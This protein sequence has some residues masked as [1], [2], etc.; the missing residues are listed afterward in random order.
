MEPST[1]WLLCSWCAF[2]SEPDESSFS[3]N[4]A[5]VDWSL[6]CDIKVKVHQVGPNS[7]VSI[8]MRNYR[9][10]IRP[11]MGLHV[12][13]QKSKAIYKKRDCG[14][15]VCH[16]LGQKS[17]ETVN[18]GGTERGFRNVPSRFLVI[19]VCSDRIRKHNS[20]IFRLCGWFVNGQCECFMI[21]FHRK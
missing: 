10:I 11:I 3:H 15:L 6:P 8:Q 1:L 13:N 4:C 17:L 5:I 16:E 21:K 14:H 18:E 12:S 2:T 7:V 20:F 9:R 19:V